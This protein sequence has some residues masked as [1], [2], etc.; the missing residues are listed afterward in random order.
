MEQVICTVVE[1]GGREVTLA[2]SAAQLASRTIGELITAQIVAVR[3][4]ND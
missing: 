2:M 1:P 4:Q 3:S